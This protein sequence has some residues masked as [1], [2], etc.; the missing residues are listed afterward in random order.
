[1]LG[2]AGNVRPKKAFYRRPR[3]SASFLFPAFSQ[4]QPKSLYCPSPLKG[5]RIYV[6]ISPSCAILDRECIEYT[7][8]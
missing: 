1:M 7:V 8:T 5:V 4:A 3:S 6:C 2:D